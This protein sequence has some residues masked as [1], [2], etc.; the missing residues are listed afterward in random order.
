MCDQSATDGCSSLVD[1]VTRVQVPPV[2]VPLQFAARQV[3]MQA[4]A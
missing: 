1:M 3:R 2:Q 4:L